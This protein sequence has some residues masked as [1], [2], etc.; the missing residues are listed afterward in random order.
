V[1]RTRRSNLTS[2]S[3]IVAFSRDFDKEK[4][5]VFA[6]QK[7][8]LREERKRQAKVSK[9]QNGKPP[10]HSPAQPERPLRAS[11]MQ[12]SMS[13]VL[14]E[15]KVR[16]PAVEPK[17]V[18]S[19]VREVVAQ[20]SPTRDRYN[21]PHVHQNNYSNSNL[22][23]KSPRSSSRSNDET[24]QK[25]AYSNPGPENPLPS[26]RY[27]DGSVQ[28]NKYSNAPPRSPRSSNRRNDASVQESSYSNPAARSP[29][30][31]NHYNDDPPFA[32]PH[33]STD[34][35]SLTPNRTPSSGNAS[36]QPMQAPFTTGRMN[37]ETTRTEAPPSTPVS[38]R[39]ATAMRQKAR[40]RRQRMQTSISPS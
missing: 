27:N 35:E 29:K 22:T 26:N 3:T 39:T 15:M 30:S 8:D 5:K 14:A 11:N 12:P 25:S 28:Q 21:D 9:V 16:S 40:L 17:P 31:S 19:P 1:K 20:E 34:K 23:P 33:R 24:I 18:L 37:T 38:A 32:T 6:K 7:S 36:S 10:P 4:E 2:S 13:S